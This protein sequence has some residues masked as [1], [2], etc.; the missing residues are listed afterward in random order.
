MEVQV[1]IT[2]ILEP[3][4]FLGKDGVTTYT[5]YS[6]VGTTFGDYPRTIYFQTLGQDKYQQMNIQLGG[7]Y[8]ISFDIESRK[9]NDKYFT[10][11]N[12]WKA[13]RETEQTVTQPQPNVAYQAP[14]PQSTYPSYGQAPQPM[15]QPPYDPNT[16]F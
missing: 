14:A 1:K 6:F 16:P 2:E 5:R 12:A 9:Y 8:T 13:V 4:S 15:A 7:I 11:I 3:Q 10:S